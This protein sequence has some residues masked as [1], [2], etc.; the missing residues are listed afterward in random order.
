MHNLRA[1]LYELTIHM[2][3]LNN[4]LFSSCNKRHYPVTFRWITNRL[5]L[6]NYYHLHS[7][8][9]TTWNLTHIKMTS[10][11]INNVIQEPR[12]QIPDSKIIEKNSTENIFKHL[13]E[14]CADVVSFDKNFIQQELQ[15]KNP[16]LGS[17]AQLISDPTGFHKLLQEQGEKKNPD[18]SRF[19]TLTAISNRITRFRMKYYYISA[20]VS[21]APRT[22]L[23]IN[24][25]IA[26]I[27]VNL[28]KDK[29]ILDPELAPKGLTITMEMTANLIKRRL[30][31][32]ESELKTLLNPITSL[33]DIPEPHRI[34]F[35]NFPIL[36]DSLKQI[37]PVGFVGWE[38]DYYYVL[39]LILDDNIATRIFSKDQFKQ[40]LTF[41]G[42]IHHLLVFFRF[43]AITPETF[44]R[45]LTKDFHIMNIPFNKFLFPEAPQVGPTLPGNVTCPNETFSRFVT[46]SSHF[47][48]E[49]YYL[50]FSHTITHIKDKYPDRV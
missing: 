17:F 41:R 2:Y 32:M 42:E 40:W 43:G 37:A 13:F 6:F 48:I 5:N 46:A 50:A 30:T 49:L 27:W 18:E 12:N 25:K 38:C 33:Y 28:C 21:K 34:D 24:A 10:S 45:F 44:S 14:T 47:I 16:P 9:N 31:T 22:N 20:L 3:Y 1:R 7:V 19:N 23:A 8:T 15:S 26:K 39:S 29:I 36:L 35:W 11:N 4:P